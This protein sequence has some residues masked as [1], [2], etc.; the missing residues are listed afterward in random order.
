LLAA[1]G[2]LEMLMEAAAA[3]RV[4]YFRVRLPLT[5]HC[6]TQLLLVRVALEQRLLHHQTVQI[7]F[8][9]Q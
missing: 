4:A 9:M 7:L 6:H 3:V 8:L 2:L 1:A 5:Q